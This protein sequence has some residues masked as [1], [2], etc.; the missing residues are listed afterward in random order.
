MTCA[1][2]IVELVECA[3]HEMKPGRGL[4]AHL[5]DCARCAERWEAERQLTDRFRSIRTAAQNYPLPVE[6]R[7]LLQARFA[8]TYSATQP[9]R[10]V[11]GSWTWGLGAAA[12]LLLA[13]YAGHLAGTRVRPRQ[14]PA[15]RTH[16]IRS[17]QTVLYEVSSDASALSSDDFIAVPYAPPLAQGEIV[18]VVHTDLYP[19]ALASLGIGVDP[20]SAGDTPA[21]VVVGEDGTPRAVRITEAAQQ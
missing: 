7:Q 6:Q 13:I 16:E 8:L 14:S 15:V 4:Q 18:R 3:R 17:N 21:D 5:S 12:A 19:E 9:R 20:L 10:A 11:R 2:R 1:E